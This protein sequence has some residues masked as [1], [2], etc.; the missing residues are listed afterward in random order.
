M[1]STL[2]ELPMTDFNTSVTELEPG[3]I[4]AYV[5]AVGHAFGGIVLYGPFDSLQ[6]AQA[7]HDDLGFAE[8][9]PFDDGPT[10]IVPVFTRFPA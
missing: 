5:V 10:E 4:G 2:G 7:W 9:S 3:N 8:D 6:E 1:T